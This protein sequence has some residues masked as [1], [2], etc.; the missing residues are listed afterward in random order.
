MVHSGWGENLP[1]R[2][3]FPNARLINYCEFYYRP[4]GQD[5]GF[6][7]DFPILTVDGTMTLA[8][9]NATMLLGLVDCDA[10]L[11]PTA[12]QRSTFPPE[13]HPKIAVAHEGIDTDAVAPDPSARFEAAPGRVFTR[14]TRS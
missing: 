11:S 3:V 1:L 2:A 9:K 10:G 8:M 7:P 4:E 6:D 5:V 14:G 13:F 12:W